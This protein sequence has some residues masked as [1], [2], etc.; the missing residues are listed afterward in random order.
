MHRVEKP[1]IHT[2]IV[3]I[4]GKNK[5]VSSTQLDYDNINL[6]IIRFYLYHFH[7]FFSISPIIDLPL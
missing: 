3:G 2:L 5:Y 6:S 7:Q 1:F 4:N